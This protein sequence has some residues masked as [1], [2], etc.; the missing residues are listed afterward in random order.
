MCSFILT[1]ALTIIY[2]VIK[3]GVM[4]G[5]SPLTQESEY[6][7][8]MTITT[9]WLISAAVLDIKELCKD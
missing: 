9:S 2:V 4:L 1:T 3:I 8:L 6:W 5:D 7:W